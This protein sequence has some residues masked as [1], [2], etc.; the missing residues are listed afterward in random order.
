MSEYNKPPE[1]AV[2][3]A[4]INPHDLGEGK[5]QDMAKR[6][7]EFEE[8][9][10]LVTKYGDFMSVEK[11]IKRLLNDGKVDSID[12]FREYLIKNRE[13]IVRNLDIE[14]D[15]AVEAIVNENVKLF[16]ENDQLKVEAVKKD[17]SKEDEKERKKRKKDIEEAKK[18]IVKVSTKSQSDFDDTFNS[19]PGGSA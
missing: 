4:T 9:N 12:S 13:E 3:E 18:I 10:R 1:S 11:F 17:L 16:W 5:R 8:K 15:A 14:N 19:L 2:R 6:T 7:K